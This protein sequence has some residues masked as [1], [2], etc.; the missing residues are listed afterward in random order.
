[1]CTDICPCLEYGSNPSSSEVY[2]KN[3]LQLA[4]HNRT[5]D[6]N[7]KTKK[8]M[9]FTDDDKRGFRNF[10]DCYDDWYERSMQDALIDINDVFVVKE[11]PPEPRGRGGRGG[12][13]GPG[14]GGRD[15]DDDGPR[16]RGRG[17]RDDDD[18]RDGRRGG[19]GGRGG[20][21]RRRGPPTPNYMMSHLTQME[22][23]QELED[24]Y[25]CSGMCDS[26]LFY[27]GIDIHNGIPQK[28]CIIDFR[29]YVHDHVSGFASVSILA[30]IISL[31]LFL[32]HFSMYCRP[33]DE[34]H[35]A[36]EIPRGSVVQEGNDHIEMP[37]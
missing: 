34:E 6:E 26:S 15:D 18:D 20:H 22:M 14:R 9:K 1:M 13:G 11:M 24:T 17:G 7:D 4:R 19:P 8:F 3:A 23:Y 10:D 28:T 31:I 21:R 33:L 25:E 32:V 37:N 2:Q 12:R 16:G 29:D 35:D 30:G 5:F 27:F 36:M